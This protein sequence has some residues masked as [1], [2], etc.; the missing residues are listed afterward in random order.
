MAEKWSGKKI[1]FAGPSIT[2][3]ELDYATDAVKNGWYE[4]FDKHTRLLEKKV[5]DYLGMK[6]SLATH[7]CTLALHLAN[8]SLG[9]GPGD[10]VICTD[11]SWVATAYSI[12]YTGAK[13][14]FVDIEPDS[15]C[16][17]PDAI[18]KAITP[19][20]K[21]IMIVHSFGHPA[22]MDEIKEIATEHNLKLIED[23]APSLGSRFQGRLT[24]TFGDVACFSFQGAKIAASG[25]GG[26]LV[27]NNE[28][29]YKKALLL[30][31]MGR[32]DSKAVFWSDMLGF[33]YTIGNISAALALAQVERIDELVANKRKIFGYYHARLKDIPGLKLLVE[34]EGCLSNYTY[35]SLLL[36]DSIK[37]NRDD[38][39]KR[40]K[41]RNIHPRPTFP[42]MSTFPTLE[43]RFPNPIAAKIS[44]RGISLP[45]AH[46][47]VE[48]DIDFVVESLLELARMPTT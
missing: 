20:T 21:G 40:L 13:P 32:T 25:E 43:A 10:E 36:E 41:A 26:I 27:T 29:I 28:E 30:A 33:Q 11:F 45:A 1:S 23:A 2:Q 3:K 16:I 31:N 34:Q 9:F 15:W 12:A 19:K 22:K 44:Q 47:L 35:P 38:I 46:N 48:E 7:C 6:Y 4:T 14:V 39:I 8:A 42:R 18:R 17:S 5:C 37:A 24:G